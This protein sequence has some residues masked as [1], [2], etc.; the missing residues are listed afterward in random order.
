MNTTNILLVTTSLLVLVAFTLSF[1]KFSRDSGS[2]DASAE[3]QQLD[4]EIA[5]LE[6]EREA[7]RLSAYRT[8]PAPYP[9]SPAAVPEPAAPEP[10]QS[11]ISEET[12]ADLEIVRSQLEEANRKN[13]VLEKETSMIHKRE[14]EEAQRT[15]EAEKR[16][17]IAPLMGTID[18]VNTEYGFLTFSAKNGRSFQ[19]GQELGIRRGSGILGRVEVSSVQGDE[20]S[21]NIKPNA[22]AGGLPPVRIGDE[23]IRLPDNYKGE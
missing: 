1:G 10:V 4:A 5:R 12:A 14:T 22:Y 21:A 16:V 6:S 18:S 8:P 15:E 7:L 13:E 11:E 3:R 9:I 20:Y 23:L 2:S 17:R 19:Q